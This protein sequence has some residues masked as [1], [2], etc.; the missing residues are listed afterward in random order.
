MSQ[1]VRSAFESIYR[2]IRP[3]AKSRKSC[4]ILCHRV[5]ALRNLLPM[6][7]CVSGVEPPPLPFPL[8][9][10][11]SPTSQVTGVS[12]IHPPAGHIS[13]TQRHVGEKEGK[14]IK[15]TTKVNYIIQKCCNDT[16]YYFSFAFKLSGPLPEFPP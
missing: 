12:S 9:S 15:V 11:G 7:V 4:L 13:Y 2:Y 6:D 16:C 3:E 14:Q 5:Y 8:E 10:C 1:R